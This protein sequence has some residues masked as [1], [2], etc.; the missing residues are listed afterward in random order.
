MHAMRWRYA[1][2]LLALT[3]IL[4]IASCAATSD[5]CAW[6][7]KIHVQPG[8]VISRPTAEAIVSHNRAVEKFCR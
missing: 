8:D 5:G 2:M 1:R 7:Q 3:M 6:I 4:F